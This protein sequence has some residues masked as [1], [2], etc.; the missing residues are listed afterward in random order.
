MAAPKTMFNAGVMNK[1]N[2]KKLSLQQETCGSVDR[3]HH[4]VTYP[5]GDLASQCN[6]REGGNHRHCEPEIKVESWRNVYA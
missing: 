4:Q 6:A 2:Q 3:C 5:G 1:L